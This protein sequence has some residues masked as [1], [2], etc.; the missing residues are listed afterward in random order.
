LSKTYIEVTESIINKIKKI[1]DVKRIQLKPLILELANHLALGIETKRP[2]IINKLKQILSQDTE[3]PRGQEDIS[4]KLVAQLIKKIKSQHFPSV[5]DNW[6]MKVLPKEFKEDARN[7][8]TEKIILSEHITDEN[9]Y[10]IK[11]IIK[12]RIRTMETVGPAKEIKIKETVKDVSTYTWKC[13]TA[14]EL[15]RLAIKME[16][17]HPTEHDMKY[18]DKSSRA[19]K[20]ARDGRFATTMSRYEAIVVGAEH[21][22]SLANVAEGEFEHLKRWELE[23]NE[24]ACTECLSRDHCAAT[25]CNHVCHAIVKPLTTKGVKWAIRTN[26]D[27]AELQT[28][29][30]KLQVESDDM[31]PMMKTIFTNPHMTKKLT[32]GDK[33]KLMARHTELAA[34][35]GDECDQCV[36][37]IAM[38]PNFFREHLE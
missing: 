28:R 35:G 17:E 19:I 16:Q 15:A 1:D 24:K 9:L 25:Q 14:Q 26:K 30:K 27:L 3:K 36:G 13:P 18:C 2:E 22:K 29:I 4:V 5:S 6:I 11:D 7:K 12:Q 34:H 23:G 37:F 10:R 31:C 21:T 33:K 8:P 38:H 20:M 32:M